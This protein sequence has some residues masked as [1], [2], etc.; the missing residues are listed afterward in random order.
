MREERQYGR[1]IIEFENSM[2]GGIRQLR[3]ITER[4]EDDEP[5]G[6]RY[7]ICSWF[8]GGHTVICSWRSKEQLTFD[9]PKDD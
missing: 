7:E 3:E 1:V 6:Y 5:T 2:E 9:T 8:Y 4:D